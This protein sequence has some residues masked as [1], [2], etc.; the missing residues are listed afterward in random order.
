[1]NTV[2]REKSRFQRKERLTSTRR[3]PQGLQFLASFDAR[4]SFKYC[5][6]FPSLAERVFK[7]NPKWKLTNPLKTSN[8]DGECLA[9]SRSS[10]SALIAKWPPWK[11]MTSSFGRHGAVGAL[12]GFSACLD[13]HRQREREHVRSGQVG[14]SARLRII[15][16]SNSRV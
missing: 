12:M 4:L 11:A 1:M 8:R 10:R 14:R 15:S 3:Y 7:A 2:G 16:D 5:F 9:L 13:R 6:A